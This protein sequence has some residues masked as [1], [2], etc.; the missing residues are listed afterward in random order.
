MELLHFIVDLDCDVYLFAEKVLSARQGEDA[1]ISLVKGRYILTFVSKE[2]G[3]D[4]FRTCIHIVEDNSDSVNFI[5]T[6]LQEILELYRIVNED[7]DGFLD[8]CV[9]DY[10]GN[11]YS[12]DFKSLITGSSCSSIHLDSRCEVIRNKAF[13]KNI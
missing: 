12:K 11:L 1:R 13:S 4:V 10:Q 8:D 2:F 5:D 7:Y 3:Y 6:Q 9:K